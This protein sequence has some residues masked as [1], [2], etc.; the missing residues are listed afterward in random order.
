MIM[1]HNIITLNNTCSWGPNLWVDTGITHEKLVAKQR[2]A[3]GTHGIPMDPRTRRPERPSLSLSLSVVTPSVD[4]KILATYGA[5]L[6]CH[7]RCVF[8][9]SLI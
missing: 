9:L 6:R 4:L 8:L 7:F 2:N 1:S 3:T 5:N